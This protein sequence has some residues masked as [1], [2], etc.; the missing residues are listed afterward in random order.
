MARDLTSNIKAR[1][2]LGRGDSQ[3]FAGQARECTIRTPL[4]FDGDEL[5]IDPD[6]L[7]D[8][9][10]TLTHQQYMTLGT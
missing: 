7:E 4:K 3:N 9:L 10:E 2:I 5:T 8:L 1:R 6:E